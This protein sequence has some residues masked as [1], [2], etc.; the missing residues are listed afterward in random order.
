MQTLIVVGGIIIAFLIL[1]YCG[2]EAH[3]D[4]DEMGM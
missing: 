3:E 4:L 1:A 2:G